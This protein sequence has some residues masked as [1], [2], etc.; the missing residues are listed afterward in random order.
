MKGRSHCQVAG[1]QGLSAGARQGSP[2]WIPLNLFHMWEPAGGAALLPALASWADSSSSW[3]W[4]G[5][6]WS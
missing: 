6:V 2:T 3:N 4:A 1:T 5:W